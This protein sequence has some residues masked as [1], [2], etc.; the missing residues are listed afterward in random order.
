MICFTGRKPKSKFIQGSDWLPSSVNERRWLQIGLAT[1]MIM[2][3]TL[4]FHERLA[5]WDSVMGAPANSGHA[6]TAMEIV[7]F[8]CL[9]AILCSFF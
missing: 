2:N 6:P 3:K 7:I 5:F 4:P 9:L 8:A 1:Q